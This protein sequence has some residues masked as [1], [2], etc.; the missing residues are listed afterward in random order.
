[1]NSIVEKS[2]KVDKPVC[3]VL[4][5]LSVLLSIGVSLE[6]VVGFVSYCRS[7]EGRLVAMVHCE[8]SESEEQL[9]RDH[10][11]HV[12]HLSLQV[13]G[14]ATGYSKDVHGEVSVVCITCTSIMN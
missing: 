9:L 4:D 5:D 12:S 11:M 14:L 7:L 13:T 10:L 3:L 6:E 8:E 2:S 1:M